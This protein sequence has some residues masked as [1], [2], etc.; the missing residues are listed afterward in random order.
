[1]KRIDSANARSNAN[2]L[3]KA[4]F[5]DNAD[6]SGQDATYLTPDYLNHLQEELCNLLE[7][8]GVALNNLKKDQLYDLL[9]TYTDIEALAAEVQTKLNA[10]FDKAGGTI[11]DDV[12]IEKDLAVD[13]ELTLG[14]SSLTGENGHTYL[15]NGYIYQFGY[16]ALS[17]MTVIS[18]TS[19][20]ERYAVIDLPIPFPTKAINPNAIVKATNTGFLSDLFAQVVNPT[21]TQITVKTCT[22]QGNN[23]SDGIDGVYWSVIG[24]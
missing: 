2:G 13:G 9:A 8:N 7:K 10:K 15:P 3:G 4:G 19:T 6:L 17:D 20:D 11:T 22:I 14:T 5:H 16:I 1:M 23:N 18:Q 21:R 12:T 24:I